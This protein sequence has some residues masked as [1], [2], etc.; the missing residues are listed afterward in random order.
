MSKKEL[1]QNI[2][3]QLKSQDSA[4]KNQMDEKLLAE[5]IASPEYQKAQ[6]IATYLP[7]DF[8]Y[9]TQLFIQEAIK[10]HKTILIPKTFTAGQMVF[11]V[12]DPT[13]LE[14]NAFGLLEPRIWQAVDKDQID[15]IHVPGIAFNPQG[16]RI[17]FGGGFY[18]RYLST[19]QGA[20]VSTIYP[21]Q[22]TDFT[23]DLHD[24]AV[25]KILTYEK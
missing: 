22:L 19:Y 1:R 16:Y 11:T 2:L 23:P 21:C 7:F 15:L 6:V 8:E 20:T 4:Y 10:S 17:G 5:L 3:A 18:D 9:N 25:R 13:H 12:Y 14:K 24:I